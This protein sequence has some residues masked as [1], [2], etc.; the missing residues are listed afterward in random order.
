MSASV[1]PTQNKTFR[2]DGSRDARILMTCALVEFSS[3]RFLVKSRGKF[4]HAAITLS[5]AVLIAHTSLC[6]GAPGQT[7]RLFEVRDSVEMSQFTD[8][9]AFSPDGR[10][11]VTVTHRGLLPQGVIE[12]TSGFL[13]P[14]WRGPTLTGNK[15]QPL[16]RSRSHECRRQSMDQHLRRIEARS[17]CN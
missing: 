15:E 14:P 2:Q 8:L 1:A 6:A 17:L 4:C 12:G 11:Y 3:M 7:K 10:R 13:R 5:L 9:A 16:R